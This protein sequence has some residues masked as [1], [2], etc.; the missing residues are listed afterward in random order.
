MKKLSIVIAA[1]LV[2]FT[3]F[4]GGIVTNT[5]QSAAW[6]R[7]LVRDASVDIDAV[8][9]NPAGLTHLEDGFYIQ[10]NSQTAIQTRTITN[11]NAN[12]NLDEFI[13]ETF[14]PVL[15][16]GFLVFKKG[17]LALSGGFTFVGGGGSAEFNDG[18][19][20]FETM[21]SGVVG[22][23][24]SFGVDA[25]DA[26]IY[27]KGTSAY[28]GIQLGAS[29]K[30]NDMI[31]VGLGGRYVMANNAY[32]GYIRDIMINPGGGAMTS[33]PAFFTDVAAQA[34]GAAASADGASTSMDPII[35]GGG[36]AFTFAQ[37]EGAGFIT[38]ADRAALEGG[39]L[40]LGASSGMT[41]AQIDA[42]TAAQ[43]QGAFDAY[44]VAYTTGAA[45]AEGGAAATQDVDVD[46]VQ[47]GSGITPIISVDLT[48]MEGDLGI[49][50]KY[51]HKTTMEV[52]NETT[53][54]GSGMF[55]D[56]AVTPAEL[57]AFLSVGVRFQAMEKLKLQAGFHYYMDMDASYGKVDMNTGDFI[58]N[59]TE[60]AQVDG[61]MLS[62]LDGNSTEIALG[63]EYALND[64]MGVSAGFLTTSVSPN[65]IY[66][67]ELSY[68]LKTN[69]VGLGMYYNTDNLSL[70][71]GL[72]N[73][74]YETYEKELSSV[75]TESYTKTAMLIAVGVGYKF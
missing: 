53:V 34:T 70:D 60:F 24:A 48:F 45:Q 52:T 35:A 37:L 40:A 69:T 44:T 8:F 51:E 62:Y 43:A 20:G 10:I 19:P 57:P 32:E 27:F 46:A 30:I 38:A 22:S 63:L 66:Q 41:Q 73:T 16:T 47:T 23:A 15:P 31:S 4:A 50:L 21:V 2:S 9:Y 12:I 14:V 11:N 1:L 29:Y 39:L 42:M 13:G 72:S 67:S 6:V 28:M 54:D 3:S 7:T 75:V 64:A 58:T 36:G 74:F 61:S 26:D 33:A 59:G 25:Y 18:L 65:A 55:P 56:G 68:A 71:L 17:N 49:A 5:N